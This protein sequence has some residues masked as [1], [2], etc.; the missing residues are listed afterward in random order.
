MSIRENFLYERVDNAEDN[1]GFERVQ[2][3]IQNDYYLGMIMGVKQLDP[4][5]LGKTLT[6]LRQSFYL[7]YLASEKKLDREEV[8]LTAFD[9]LDGIG[10]VLGLEED[11]GYDQRAHEVLGLIRGGRSIS[12]GLVKNVSGKQ[13]VMV[14]GAMGMALRRPENLLMRHEMHKFFSASVVDFDPSYYFSIAGLLR[15]TKTEFN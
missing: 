1:S 8:I 5:L 4:G 14:M 3:L 9:Y 13:L 12:A 2:R 10:Q 7:V 15:L 11:G 6:R